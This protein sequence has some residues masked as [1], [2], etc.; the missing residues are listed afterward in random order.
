MGFFKELAE[1]FAEGWSEGM[2]ESK[3]ESKIHYEQIEIEE[4][5]K[6]V[7]DPDEARRK[8]KGHYIRVKGRVQHLSSYLNGFGLIPIGMENSFRFSGHFS[9]IRCEVDSSEAYKKEIRDGSIVTVRGKIKDVTRGV[10]N[11]YDMDV[12]RIFNFDKSK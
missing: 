1:A 5:L 3:P 11:V 12:H 6:D 10:E 2:G 4:M 8:Y 9:L 7:N